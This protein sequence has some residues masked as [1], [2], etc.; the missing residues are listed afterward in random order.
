MM[1]LLIQVEHLFVLLP[2]KAWIA[3]VYA[4]YPEDVSLVPYPAA[5]VGKHDSNGVKHVSTISVHKF[6]FPI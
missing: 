1:S 4:H 6:P 5:S 2:L 3:L